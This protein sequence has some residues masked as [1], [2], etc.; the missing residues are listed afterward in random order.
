MFHFRLLAT[1]LSVTAVAAFSPA[2]SV[3]KVSSPLKQQEYR[4]P[5]NLFLTEQATDLISSAWISAADG[6]PDAGSVGYSK[7][8][9]YTILGLFVMSFPGV[10]SQVKRSTAAKIKRKTYVSAGENAPE[11]KSLRQ[12]AG[13]IMA[14]E[15][16]LLVGRVSMALTFYVLTFVFSLIHFFLS[17]EKITIRIQ[18]TSIHQNHNRH[19]CKQL[20]SCRS[21]RNNYVPWTCPTQ[22]FSSTLFGLLYGLWNALF[23]TGPRHSIP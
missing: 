16:I 7:A 14:C 15:S 20:R 10:Y 17:A 21:W 19:D 13:E 8:S 1:F 4:Q 12:Q 11:G 5:T 6:L 3:S 18:T 23:G 9:Y 2:A 22:S